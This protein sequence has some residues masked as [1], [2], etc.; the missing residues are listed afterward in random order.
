LFWIKSLNK[1]KK[2]LFF[3]RR[4]WYN[5]RSKRRG[6]KV[7]KTARRTPRNYNGTEVTTRS[8]GELIP[9]VLSRISEVNQE[10]P[11]LILAAWPGIIGS[12]LAAMTQ[13]VSFTDGILVVKVKNSTLYSLLNQ[14]DKPKLLSN[15]RKKFPKVTIHNIIFRMG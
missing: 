5:E 15:L 2:R 10:R 4:L 14:N 13:A 8:L 6:L 12:N 9:S 1:I 11:D 7:L 3:W